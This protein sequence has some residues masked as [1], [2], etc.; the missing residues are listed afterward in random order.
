MDR[1]ELATV[2]ESVTVMPLQPGDYVI[3]KLKERL[4]SA[5]LEHLRDVL[6]KEFAPHGCKC[7]VLEP[8]MEFEIARP[9]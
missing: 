9:Q 7:L 1:D 6:T 3:L 4:P 5:A 8:G 2:L